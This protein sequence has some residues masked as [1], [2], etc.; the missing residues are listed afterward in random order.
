MRAQCDRCNSSCRQPSRERGQI[1]RRGVD[2]DKAIN[3]KGWSAY[4]AQSIWLSSEGI[5]REERARELKIAHSHSLRLRDCSRSTL[6]SHITQRGAAVTSTHCSCIDRHREADWTKI[7]CAA[8]IVVRGDSTDGLAKSASVVASPHQSFRHT[9]QSRR[10]V[11]RP[12]D[13]LHDPLFSHHR[14]VLD[15]ICARSGVYVTIAN[16]VLHRAIA[17]AQ[18]SEAWRK[19]PWATIRP[20]TASTS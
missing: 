19:V 3:R 9:D 10:P 18:P 1:R 20:C 7:R 4:H 13:A 11:M 15:T 2:V 8:Q 14:R 12:H 16:S 17:T 5:K 6:Q